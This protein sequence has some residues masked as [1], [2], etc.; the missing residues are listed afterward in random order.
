MGHDRSGGGGVHPVHALEEGGALGDLAEGLVG[1][2]DQV[3]CPR[4]GHG[5]HHGAHHVHPDGPVLP[6]HQRR[7]HAPGRVHRRARDGPVVLPQ[8]KST[9]IMD[10]LVNPKAFLCF[11]VSFFSTIGKVEKSIIRK[12]KGGTS[13]NSFPKF[14]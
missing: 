10:G 1:E 5:P 2:A 7:A 6:A 12:E 14:N 4:P 8:D 9:W 3:V 13:T 11:L